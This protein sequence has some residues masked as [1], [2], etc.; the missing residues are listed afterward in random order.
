MKKII[1]GLCIVVVI[2]GGVWFFVQRKAP[3]Q[4]S[5]AAADANAQNSANTEPVT[6]G[7]TVAPEALAAEVKEKSAPKSQLSSEDEASIIK[8]K[9]A[10]S[11]VERF[12]TY[13]ADAN[14]SNLRELMP[15]MSASLRAWAQNII[16]TDKKP[17]AGYRIR[18][19]ALATEAKKGA[20]NVYIVTAQREET[21]DGTTRRIYQKATVSLVQQGENWFVDSVV[22]GEEGVL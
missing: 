19:T 3:A 17:A 6:V 1:I 22:W 12:G 11:F 14:F 21:K 15:L 2:A 18:T 8:G 13:S 16:D 9:F 7:E 20:N 4:P 10:A 5:P